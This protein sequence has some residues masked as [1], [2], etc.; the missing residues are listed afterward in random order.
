MV[1]LLYCKT[2]FIYMLT[3]FITN[4][5]KHRLVEFVTSDWTDKQ[6]HELRK[7]S[8][9][10]IL[11]VDAVCSSYNPSRCWRDNNTSSASVFLVS[12]QGHLIWELSIFSRLSS[13]NTPIVSICFIALLVK[14]CL[15]TVNIISL[16]AS[17]QKS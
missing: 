12:L 9:V 6:T 11:P 4:P 1:F 13:D 10:P 3:T 17:T 14:I 15:T 2:R 7:K 16:T 8:L 5:I